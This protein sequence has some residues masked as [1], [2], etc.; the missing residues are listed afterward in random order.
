M[1]WRI[2]KDDTVPKGAI[3][4]SHSAPKNKLRNVVGCPTFPYNTE[5]L[6]YFQKEMLGDLHLNS[7]TRWNFIYSYQAL[8]LFHKP[9]VNKFFIMVNPMYYALSGGTITS[10]WLLLK[11]EPS[12]AFCKLMS[13]QN[14]ATIAHDLL[15]P[16]LFLKN[17]KS[18]LQ[19]LRFRTCK[20]K[21]WFTLLM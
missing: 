2:V 14:S 4:L 19:F 17:K 13:C 20:S 12:P 16:K 10:T 1:E 21:L 9:K 6:K 5:I 3:S 18:F 8:I 15:A 11:K 7:L